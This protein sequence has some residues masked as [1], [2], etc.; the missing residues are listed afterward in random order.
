MKLFVYGTLKQRYGNNHRLSGAEYCGDAVIDG[1]RLVYA[2][3][4]GDF[5]FAHPS[6][7]HAIKGE[8]YDIGDNQDILSSCD[9]LEGHPSW[10]QRTPVR[11]RDNEEVSLY[12][13]PRVN[14]GSIP[15][16]TDDQ[17]IFYWDR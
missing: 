5:P 1:Y 8:V 6:E 16:P 14:E 11:T 7:G 13:M 10:Y 15:C 17:G 2:Y 9:R 4:V 3:S 12:V